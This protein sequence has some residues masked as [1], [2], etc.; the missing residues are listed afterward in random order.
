[1]PSKHSIECT[2]SSKTASAFT[3]Y[4]KTIEG[5]KAPELKTIN[6]QYLY[7]IILYEMQSKKKMCW[8]DEE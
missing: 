3:G 2:K 7:Y 6:N 8:S 5:I 4:K 1:M